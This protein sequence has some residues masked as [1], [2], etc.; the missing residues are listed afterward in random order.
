M[1]PEQRFGVS[2]VL[3]VA[4]TIWVIVAGQAYSTKQFVA[5]GYCEQNQPGAESARWVKCP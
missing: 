1:D 2:L 3:L 5:G 4:I